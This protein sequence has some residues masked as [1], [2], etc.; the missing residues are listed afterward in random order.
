MGEEAD[1]VERHVELHHESGDHL[2]YLRVYDQWAAAGHSDDWCRKYFIHPRAV[3]LARN[4]RKQLQDAVQGAQK[5][6]GGGKSS[7]KSDDRRKE[8]EER[9]RDSRREGVSRRE[10][11]GSRDRRRERSG[12]RD[13][14]RE[15]SGSRDRRRERS[16]S[17][18]RRRERS[19]SRDRR[20]ERGRDRDDKRKR[21]VSRDRD[22]GR[23]RDRSR[24]R[25]R[26]RDRSS[27]RRRDRS[28]D[29]PRDHEGKPAGDASVP[30]LA[31]VPAPT[32]ATP[33]AAAAAAAAAAPQKVYKIT[34]TKEVGEYHNSLV[35]QLTKCIVSGFYF[36]SA[37]RCAADTFKL[38]G[39]GQCNL[40][41][42]HPQS[43]LSSFAAPAAV[44]FHEVVFTNRGHMRQVTKCSPKWL[45]KLLPRSVGVDIARLSG[46]VAL[47]DDEDPHDS[48]AAAA[49]AFLPF[50]CV[51]RCRL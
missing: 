1:A 41:F 5:E 23:R 4:I 51:A 45:K 11:S 28:R 10:R 2:T 12:S 8:G 20:R 37:T 48:G 15:R 31:T 13:R 34:R 49:G 27:D 16:G 36:H 18:E 46:R 21:S 29:R 14:R 3:K 47:A 6:A 9:R 19:G 33:V 42:I 50:V 39:E 35:K 30:A 7:S 32:A 22:G 40:A 17:R 44:V 26:D 43:A 38:T 24:D 25:S